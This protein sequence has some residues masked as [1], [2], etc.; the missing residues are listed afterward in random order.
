MLARS[1]GSI[2]HCADSRV[3]VI[4]PTID[5]VVPLSLT[6]FFSCSLLHY[7]VV[8]KWVVSCS[9]FWGYFY[10]VCRNAHCFVITFYAEFVGQHYEEPNGAKYLCKK[11]TFNDFVDVARFLVDKKKMTTPN[12]L[13]CEGRSA[14]GLL[15]GAVIN[16][17][18][19]LFKMAILGVPFVDV[20]CT[21]IDAS[22]PLTTAE[23]EEWGNPSEQ[24]FFSYMMEYS[25]VNNVKK[26][27]KYP[28]CLLTGGLHDSRVACKSQ[29]YFG[30][31]LFLFLLRSFV[32][33]INLLFVHCNRLGAIQV[34]C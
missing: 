17:A 3:N 15:I 8:E 21:M 20:V 34:C 13:S 25:P 19:E 14:G 16:Q 33:I 29:K 27:A 4:Y 7:S 31:M 5:F 11:N 32:L 10:G 1:W 28:S 26:D 2:C 12:M 22:I 23:W 30:K 24:K 6:L 9:Y 18:P